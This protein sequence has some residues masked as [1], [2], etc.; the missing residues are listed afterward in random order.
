[1]ISYNP[2]AVVPI[3]LLGAAVP[4]QL[5]VY[6]YSESAVGAYATDS[7]TPA[8]V[9]KAAKK[10]YANTNRTMQITAPGVVAGV[11]TH[12]VLGARGFR[13]REYCY[14]D[15]TANN[16]SAGGT[17]A[18]TS[19][20]SIKQG[21]HSFRLNVR[22]VAKATLVVSMTG[23][24]T[25]NGK[26]LV[27]VDIGADK[28]IEFNQTLTGKFVRQTF[29]ISGG[30]PNPVLVTVNG[31]ASW[32]AKGSSYDMSVVAWVQSP[33]RTDCFINRYGKP[34]GMV[35]FMG[36]DAPS[37]TNRHVFTLNVT[38]APK[39]ASSILAI[40]FVPIEARIGFPCPLHLAPSLFLNFKTDAKGNATIPANVNGK[41]NLTAY[42]QCAVAD[43]A[44]KTMRL[45]NGLRFDCTD[46]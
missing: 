33:V 15:A 23:R 11:Q 42:M 2:L 38:G 34:C 14:I 31:S 41:L 8:L 44:A 37:S 45:T 10:Y 6:P 43:T 39:S 18:S 17:T 4:A 3:F 40:G 36:F 22:G 12:R 46:K 13:I 1:M 30:S 24:V 16:Q 9:F 19:K 20:T 7:K 26:V 27:T 5:Q 28:K 35:D 21:V 29:P 25:G 32:A